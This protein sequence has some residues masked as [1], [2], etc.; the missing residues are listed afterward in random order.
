MTRSNSSIKVSVGQSCSSGAKEVN[1]DCLGVQ[2]P[3]EETI[4]LKGIAAVVS[5]GVSAARYGKE[6]AEM[7]VQG[8]LTDYFSTPDSWAVKKS[9]QKIINSLNRWLYG[10]SQAVALDAEKGYVSTMTALVLHSNSA[11]IFH[12]GDTRI[13]RIRDGRVEVVTRDHSS[14][15]ATDTVYL[16][17]A[18]GLNLSPKVDFRELELEVGDIFLMS[19][20]GVHEY[21]SDQNILK[22]LELDSLDGA[23]SCLTEIALKNKSPDNLTALFVRVDSLPEASHEEMQRFLLER[24]FPPALLPGNVI[25][26]LEVERVLF[27]SSRSQLYRVTDKETGIRYAMKTPSVNFADDPAYIERFAI[28]EWV[29]KRVDNPH[30]VK[31]LERE[32][33]PRFLYYLMEELVGKNFQQVMNERGGKL[34]L[35]ETQELVGQALVGLRALHRKEVLHQD[36]K[37]DNIM[38]CE[39][40]VVKL[41]DY[42]ACSVASMQSIEVAHI[43]DEIVG[44]LDYTAPEYRLGKKGSR[45]SDLFSVAMI[46]YKLLSGG[47]HPYGSAWKKAKGNADFKNLRYVSVREH[48]PD[49]PRSVDVTL[50]RALDCDEK[51]RY[52]SLSEFLK[53]LKTAKEGSSHS[54]HVPFLETNT[55][56]F[57]KFVSGFLFLVVIVLSV[58]LLKLLQLSVD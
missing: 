30:L 18:M 16:N 35:K 53:D 38:L 44:T 1:E 34:T 48:T 36:L 20:D 28:E 19:S 43:R 49:L 37:L 21:V 12:I 8:F 15:I 14:K 22:A 42:G 47:K 13:S 56:F 40:G 7:C 54:D 58:V 33:K 46:T 23:A 51:K 55:I 32:K 25:D 50:A 2:I 29:G 41:I 52:E 27:E 57:W 9:C 10:Q 3:D 17:R 24:P 6:A 45:Q 26:G 31:V 11:S 4:L 39:D 5:D